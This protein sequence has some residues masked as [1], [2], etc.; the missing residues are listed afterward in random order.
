[1]RRSP[2]ALLL[3]LLP[4]A[5]AA[6][7][8]EPPPPSGGAADGYAG[9]GEPA[10]FVPTVVT[11]SEA[12]GVPGNFDGHTVM[13]DAFLG[14]A[15]AI[16]EAQLQAFLERTP[17][18]NRSWIADA[19]VPDGRRAAAAIIAACREFDINPIAVLARMQVEQR[20]IST[21]SPISTKARDYTL[22]CGCPDNRPCN[23]AYKGLYKQ[24]QCGAQTMRN[25]Y[26]DSEAGTGQWRRGHGKRTLD[27]YDI[28]PTNHATASMY[29]YT[30]WRGSTSNKIGNWLVWNVTLKFARHFADAGVTLP[31]G[32]DPGGEPM[33][34]RGTWIGEAC[35]AGGTCGF[36]DGF[37]VEAAGGSMCSQSCEGYCP[38]RAGAAVTFC[39]D[40]SHFGGA[41]GGLCTVKA[42]SRN[43]FCGALGMEAWSLPRFVGNSSAPASTATVC[44][45][46]PSSP[47]PEAP[48]PEIPPEGTPPEGTPPEGM[49]P[50]GSPPEGTPPEGA[51]G[52][53]EGQT[54]I[55]DLGGF[56][57]VADCSVANLQ[58]RE[59]VC[60]G[61]GPAAPASYNDP[62]CETID[63]LGVCL[64]HVAVYCD[65]YG[66]LYAQDC[67]EWGTR[68][69]WGDDGDGNWC[70]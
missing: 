54:A 5:L 2:R 57:D 38:D 27:G 68:C 7:A 41:G 16:T 34:S 47:Q 33:P 32:N 11:K 17:Y 31:G 8:D 26:A 61:P 10:D 53:C 1:M 48:L 65:R 37:C 46:P 18:G 36:A 12:L 19:T 63:F 29:A 40:A 59:G 39:V 28:T 67:V 70:R 64:G 56:T 21:S 23:T 42:D 60:A 62:R 14:A 66:H 20:A 52:R 35:G 4:L 15:D 30:P 44:V 43:G 9:H 6:C 55:R 50:E 58:C 49:P 13:D 51:F 3:T 22:G 69:G 45:F 25:R 24:V